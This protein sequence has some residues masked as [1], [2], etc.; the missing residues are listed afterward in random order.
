MSVELFA[1][2]RQAYESARV[3]L[4]RDKK[5]AII[6]PTG[7]GKSFI[8]F[9]LAEDHCDQVICWLSPSEYIVHTQMENWKEAGGNTL[10]N[11][12]F[13]TYARLM[14]LTETEMEEI[15]PDYIVLDEFHRCGAEMWGEGVHK[16]LKLFANVPILGLSATAIR[17]LDNQRDMAEE[18]FDRR[19]ASEISLGEAIVR[20]ILP[21]P[22]YVTTIFHYQ[23]ELEKYQNRVFTMRSTGIRDIN[24]K[25]LDALRRTLEKADGLDVIFKRHM[26]ERYGRYIVFCANVEHMREMI[27]YVPEWFGEI[28]PNP[29]CY[30]MH[31]D[32]PEANKEFAA[33]KADDSE[34]LKLLFCIDMLNEGIHVK[35]ISGVILFRPT[36]S[37]M[38]YK[39]Q[40][41]RA[42]TA[43]VDQRPLIID[44]VNNVENLCSI[45]S[46][47]EEMAAAALWLRANGRGDEIVTETFAVEEQ[48]QDCRK[49]FAELENSLNSTW[50]QYFQEAKRFSEEH[51]GSLL[52]MPRRYVSENGLS[53]G[54]WIQTQKLVRAGRQLGSLTNSQIQRLD[55]IGMVWENKL[56][57]QFERNFAYAKAYYQTFGNLMVPAKYRTEDG[58]YL[59]AWISNIRQQYGNGEKSGVLNAER[60][61]RLNSI[62]MCW[63]VLSYTW[64]KNFNEAVQ[65]YKLHGTIDVPVSTRTES[66]FALGHWLQNMRS[67]RKGQSKQRMLTDDQIKRLDQLGMRWGNYYENQWMTAYQTADIPM[68]KDREGYISRTVGTMYHL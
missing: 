24:Q 39:Q 8:G 10:A 2:N 46:L 59:G 32:L 62:G 36:V 60:I 67:A 14:N 51:N 17:Y 28:D 42:L 55:H 61:E 4:E 52:T 41:G 16:L 45:D 44:V 43:G 11:I 54:S 33:F 47:Q 58:F 68:E 31:A 38:I 66:G 64:E 48:I 9:Q 25:Y 5:A 7:T 22:K 21:T 3:M 27:G 30:T 29:H 26:T 12:C 34:H 15:H 20:G 18:L 40:V 50:E 56:E 19:I 37:P 23:K 35:G 1:H 53:V 57:L 63:D 6:H 65:Y 13:F 49:L